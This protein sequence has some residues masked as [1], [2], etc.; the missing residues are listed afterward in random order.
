MHTHG[1]LHRDIK[2]ENIFV[3][4][5]GSVRLGDFG[6]SKELNEK[7]YATIAGTKFIYN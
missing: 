7:Y 5:D 4:E 1:V 3:M 2:P 6:L